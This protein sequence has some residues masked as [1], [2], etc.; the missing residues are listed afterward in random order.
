MD[1]EYNKKLWQ[2]AVNNP[3]LQEAIIKIRSKDSRGYLLL[4]RGFEK[5]LQE[6]AKTEEDLLFHA[7]MKKLAENLTVK[8][9]AEITSQVQELIAYRE[10]VKG[11]KISRLE[12]TVKDIDIT[13]M[14]IYILSYWGSVYFSEDGTPEEALLE[15]GIKV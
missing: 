12:K 13:S 15:K 9:L 3:S 8:D 2:I 7:E 4:T 1:S 10:E 11:E 6:D 5:I 14:A